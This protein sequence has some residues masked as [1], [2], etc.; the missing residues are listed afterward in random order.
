ML[1]FKY[2]FFSKTSGKTFDTEEH[3]SGITWHQ[4]EDCE[5]ILK[6][7]YLH[8]SQKDMDEAVGKTFTDK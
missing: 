5:E 8:A 7:F 6:V 1:S 4:V 2:L 3:E